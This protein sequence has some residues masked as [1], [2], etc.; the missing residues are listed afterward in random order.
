MKSITKLAAISD[1]LDT[2][3][4][5]ESA[6]QLDQII[7][8]LI[9]V[10]KRHPKVNTNY[11][12]PPNSANNKSSKGRFPIPDLHNAYKALVRAK[13]MKFVP[14]W[15]TG[16]SL[17]SLVNAIQQAVHSKFPNMGK[18][19]KATKSKGTTLADVI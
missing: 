12:F 19:M 2:I 15:Y 16:P 17:Q 10:A 14:K 1:Q 3:S 11:I 7:G 5:F 6:D 4:E 9:T 13:Q 8:D 18:D